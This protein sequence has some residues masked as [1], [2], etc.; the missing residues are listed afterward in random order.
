MTGPQSRS[1]RCSRRSGNTD[2][3]RDDDP[4]QVGPPVSQS[5]I[6]IYAPG[7]L[8]SVAPARYQP[9]MAIRHGSN[10]TAICSVSANSADQVHDRMFER[11]QFI[12]LIRP[13]LGP[14]PLPGL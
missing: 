6:L 3:M 9:A 14:A 4:D 2:Q 13:A 1:G 7:W 11:N 5:R 8:R 10:E 12:D